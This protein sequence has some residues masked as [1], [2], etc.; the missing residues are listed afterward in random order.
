MTKQGL[1]VTSNCV[2]PHSRVP[3]TR[4]NVFDH[5]MT[6]GKTVWSS[7]EHAPSLWKAD[8]KQVFTA[9]EKT[10]RGLQLIY[11]LIEL[12]KSESVPI[13][14]FSWCVSLYEE[15]TAMFLT[16]KDRYIKTALSDKERLR[17][18]AGLPLLH[19]Y[20][21]LFLISYRSVCT[22]C[23]RNFLSQPLPS[24]LKTTVLFHQQ[25]SLPYGWGMNA[26]EFSS[27]KEFSLVYRYFSDVFWSVAPADCSLALVP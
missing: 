18:W 7:H 25:G 16:L 10:W 5:E 15:Q 1:G 17:I 8:S 3:E 27:N 12:L 6:R 9:S 20:L 2:K 13:R 23:C 26:L 14:V 19:S 24:P 21:W 22:V 4:S 11:G